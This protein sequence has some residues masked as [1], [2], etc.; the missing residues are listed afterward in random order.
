MT[1]FKKADVFLAEIVFTDGTATKSNF[2]ADKF[3]K[4]FFAGPTR[5]PQTLV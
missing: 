5:T 2:E 1:S 3:Q 4:Q